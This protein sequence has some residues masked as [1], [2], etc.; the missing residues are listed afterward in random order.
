[1]K[2]ERKEE[3]L[4]PAPK[5]VGIQPWLFSSQKKRERERERDLLDFCVFTFCPT[6]TSKFEC[7][8]QLFPATKYTY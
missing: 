4:P 1:M 3:A 6:K 8:G 2:S 5:V 7:R